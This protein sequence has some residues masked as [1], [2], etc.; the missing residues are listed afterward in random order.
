MGD[1]SLSGYALG[2]VGMDLNPLNVALQLGA[3]GV[4][5]LLVL[6]V[7][8]VTIPRLATSFVQQLTTCQRCFTETLNAQRQDFR[9]EMRLE[10][11]AT[12]HRM[13]ELSKDVK[14]LSDLVRQRIAS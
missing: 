14:E 12:D 7:F 5:S 13:G 11:A 8:R 2:M 1:A 10:R 3:F 4:L 6:H 9:D